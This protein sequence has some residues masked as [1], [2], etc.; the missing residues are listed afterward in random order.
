MVQFSHLMP[1]Y[2]KQICENIYQFPF[3]NDEA[4]L[5]KEKTTNQ[6]KSVR[7]YAP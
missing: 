6:S 2:L 4:E 3:H 7:I 5:G 1:Q